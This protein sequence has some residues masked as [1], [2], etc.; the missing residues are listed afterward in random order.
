MARVTPIA[1]F[2]IAYKGIRVDAA[3][4]AGSD[5][6]ADGRLRLIA[7]DRSAALGAIDAGGSVIVPSSEA[8]RLQ[9]RLGDE[10]S[11]PAADGKTLRMCVAGIAERTLPGR[12]G[13]TLLM[14]W[15]DAGALG[16]RGADF[17][18]IRFAPG[19]ADSARAELERIARALALEPATFDRVQGAVSDELGR[20]LGL[21][22]ALA[23]VAV[24]VAA[25]G[26]VNT[27]TMNVVERV[28]EIGVLRATGMTR[29]QIGRMVVVE[30]GMVGLLGA[31]L[32]TVT[33]LVATALLAVVGRESLDTSVQV[34]WAA[35]AVCLALG[36]IVSMVAAWYPARL[37][38]RLS[39]VR[40][41]QFE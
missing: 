37:A 24:V 31:V 33:G 40:A 30:A 26:I 35:V 4:V 14:G 21:F 9:L 25:L 41:V 1:T 22:D 36:V 34:P 28:R 27:L 6:L 12:A 2:D 11:L 23:I 3:A 15:S 39:V 7:G 32:G 38:A 8:E 19:R 16:V 20:V 5:F 29:G 18:G 13:E 17:F 10:L